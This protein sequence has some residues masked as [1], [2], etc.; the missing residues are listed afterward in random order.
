VLLD[1]SA[2]APV[3]FRLGWVAEGALVSPDL[4]LADLAFSKADSCGSDWLRVGPHEEIRLEARAAGPL[5][6]GGAIF[7]ATRMA[8][9]GE[10]P[11]HALAKFRRLTVFGGDVLEAGRDGGGA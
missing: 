11:E 4:L 5:A 1:H 10:S 3:E 9:P 8:D 6:G 7:L 2:S